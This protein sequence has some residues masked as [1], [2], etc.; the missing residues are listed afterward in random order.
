MCYSG[1][2]SRQTPC[3]VRLINFLE[4]ANF[5]SQISLRVRVR[6]S[7]VFVCILTY[8]C[9]T[10]PLLTTKSKHRAPNYCTDVIASHMS[11]VVLDCP[12]HSM[13][14]SVLDQHVAFWYRTGKQSKGANKW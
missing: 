12:G 14:I 10:V 3:Y 7:P 6:A 4:F 8:R 13:I 11:F 5:S 1:W 2:L 9:P